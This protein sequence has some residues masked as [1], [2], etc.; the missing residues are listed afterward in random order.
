MLLRNG[1]TDSGVLSQRIANLH[2][3]SLSNKSF[4]EFQ[5]DPI[6]DENSG[7][8]GADLSLQNHVDSIWNRVV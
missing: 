3:F 7:S 8:I 1:G 4:Q 5:V 6:L 2:L